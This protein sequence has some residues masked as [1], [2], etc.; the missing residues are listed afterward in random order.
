MASIVNLGQKFGRRVVHD[1]VRGRDDEGLAAFCRGFRGQAAGGNHGAGLILPARPFGLLEPLSAIALTSSP[2]RS[3]LRSPPHGGPTANFRA[4]QH[5]H[6]R[7][8]RRHCQPADERHGTIGLP[9]V[10]SGVLSP[11]IAL[12][13]SQ[14][15]RHDPA[16]LAARHS[17][18][19]PVLVARG[20]ADVQVTCGEVRQL[21]GPG[22]APADTDFVS[23]T[24]VDHGLK[25]NSTGALINYA[26]PLPLFLAA[27]AGLRSFVDR[28]L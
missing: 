21:R 28:N 20:N 2:I 5:V 27:A 13:L 11:A 25:Q 9:P 26:K 17:P 14:L 15:D 19:L 23:L 1:G 16:Q 12:F 7:A 3:T 10:L 6:T 8:R 4:G 22:R 18:G 24:S